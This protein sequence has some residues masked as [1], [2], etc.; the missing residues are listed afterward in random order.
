M[1]G[2]IVPEASDGID[3]LDLGI[4]KQWRAWR[5]GY[6]SWHLECRRYKLDFLMGTGVDENKSIREGAGLANLLAIYTSRTIDGIAISQ[7]QSIVPGTSEPIL[8]LCFILKH[9]CG[10]LDY[11]SC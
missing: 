7:D 6:I 11:I 1:R 2:E 3:E 8:S 5:D 4:A 9:L 10:A